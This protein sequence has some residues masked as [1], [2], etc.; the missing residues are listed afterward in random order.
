VYFVFCIFF[1]FNVLVLVRKLEH[2]LGEWHTE[3]VAEREAEEKAAA[4]AK[5]ETEEKA[6]AERETE[7]KA[8]A[9]AKCETEEK[10]AADAKRDA[11]LSI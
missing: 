10:S 8:A 7:E 5:C 9:E 3:A 1:F 2:R 11:G 6:A 4:E